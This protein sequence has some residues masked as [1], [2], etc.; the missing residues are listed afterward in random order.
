MQTVD[1]VTLSTA[2]LSTELF[3]HQADTTPHP[4]ITNTPLPLP[5]DLLVRPSLFTAS[6][7]NFRLVL[8]RLGGNAK[9]VAVLYVINCYTKVDVFRKGRN[10]GREGKHEARGFFLFFQT[11]NEKRK[12]YPPYYLLRKVRTTV[13]P[14]DFLTLYCLTLLNGDLLHNAF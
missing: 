3:P 14:Q 8:S 5:F 2:A 7:T 9:V 1:P 4:A 13:D 10:N 6:C 12:T 11:N